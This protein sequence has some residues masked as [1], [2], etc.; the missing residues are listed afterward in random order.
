MISKLRS[1][2]GGSHVIALLLVVVVIGVAGF[3]GWRIFR[4]PAKK[5]SGVSQSVTP[6]KDETPKK[7]AGAPTTKTYSNS[8]Y[9]FSFEYPAEWDLTEDLRE[10]GR[11]A[12]E[13]TVTVIS[14]KGTKVHFDPNLGGKGGDCMD[15]SSQYTVKYCSTLEVI[16]AEKLD[17]GTADKPVYFYQ[18]KLTDSDTAGGST[19]YYITISNNAYFPHEPAT[20]IGAII[21]PYDEIST[22]M[23]NGM[24]GNI[25]IYVEGPEDSKNTSEKFFKTDQVE[26]AT[27]VL[28][29][30]KFL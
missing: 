4:T 15:E 24:I 28:K 26:E 6:K 8:D 27:P 14:P 29:S 25:T 21:Y 30:F 9:K 19:K 13:G 7:Q 17:V 12:K 16:K 10:L 20:K 5:T 2:E 22:I 23:S 1:H 18:M 11:G 3:A